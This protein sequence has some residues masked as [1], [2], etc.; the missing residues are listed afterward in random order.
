M[1]V[2]DRATSEVDSP[3]AWMR[4]AVAVALSTIGGVGLWS[5]VVAL[6]AVQA[7]FGTARADASLPYTLTTLGFAAGGVMM[8]RLADRFG[9]MWPVL[10]G[11]VSLGLGYILSAQAEGITG[12]AVTYGALIGL[13][14]SCAMFGPL[15]ADTSLWFRRRR[16]LAVSLCAS[17]NYFAGAV[18]PPLL[19]WG[20]ADLGWRQTHVLVGIACLCLMLPLALVLRR[21]PPRQDAPGLAAGGGGS[22]L[23]L[24]PEALQ[25]LLV[26]A[27]IACCIAMAMPQV[28]IVAYCVD[29]GYG[30][31]RGAEMLSVMLA[32]GVV[33]RLV[34]G[35]V[36]DRI[37]STATL[38]LASA[39]QAVALALFLPFDGLVPLYVIS[40]VFGLFQ[41]GIVPCY[42]V[43]VRENFPAREVGLRVSI[44][45]SATLVGMAIGG[46]MS[47]V[48][49]DL[50]GSYRMAVVNG[51]AWN[52]MHLVI[53]LWL[54]WRQRARVAYA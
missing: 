3:Y 22:A 10:L 30:A 2:A 39:L 44:A 41:G 14:G 51:L 31:A 16:G 15:V 46:W 38:L 18:W 50:T 47:G 11:T 21:P 52:G 17:G 5:I 42:A 40:G 13:F 7:E 4:L 32:C 34:F 23:G 35:V 20:I 24:P 29:L 28:H 45:L 27:G 49:F 19:Q 53:A 36:M 54:F 33:S 43:I 8:G 6:P 1:P 25:A 9:V 37:G 12:F 26:V 48:I